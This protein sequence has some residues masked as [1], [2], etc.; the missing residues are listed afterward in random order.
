MF[1]APR[2]C[3]E[4]R[5]AQPS[6]RGSVY[7][8]AHIKDNTRARKDAWRKAN[9]PV[10]KLYQ[11]VRW[12]TFRGAMLQNN[13]VCQRLWEGEQCRHPATLVHHLRSPKE[14]PDLFIVPSNCVALCE[15]CHPTTEGT[16]TWREGVDYVPTRFRIMGANPVTAE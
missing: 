16:P 9:D 14:R 12:F 10:R 5:C 6:V 4:P 3:R 1:S 15:H 7:C 13:P 11:C 2:E 8:E